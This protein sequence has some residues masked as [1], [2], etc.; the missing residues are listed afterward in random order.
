MVTSKSVLEPSA[1]L[2]ILGT[3]L[4]CSVMAAAAHRSS[5]SSGDTD[6]TAM[7]SPFSAISTGAR[8]ISSNVPN[9]SLA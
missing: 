4:K 5:Q 9:V 6:S 1:S 2:R 7:F 3:R 8:I